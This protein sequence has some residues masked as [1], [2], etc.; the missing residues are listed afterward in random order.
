MKRMMLLGC[1][2]CT[3]LPAACER[4]D[5]D[6]SLHV[7]EGGSPFT[8]EEVARL[9]SAVPLG[10]AQLG[11]VRDAVSASSVNGYDSEYTMKDLFETPGA[12]VGSEPETRVEEIG[13]AHV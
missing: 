12:G 1:L 8:L 10:E 13:R 5:N 4:L 2:C 11:E 9:L 7:Q 6:R 3:L